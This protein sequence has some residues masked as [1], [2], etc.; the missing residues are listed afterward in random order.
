MSQLI[1]PAR[2]NKQPQ[3]AP[4][5]DWANPLTR[6]LGFLLNGGTKHN[7]LNGAPP[8]VSQLGKS[9]TP[10]GSVTQ[11][12]PTTNL[13]DQYDCEITGSEVS[14]FMLATPGG[15]QT[16]DQVLSV[17]VVGNTT[18]GYGIAFKTDPSSP[19]HMRACAW[20]AANGFTA[21]VD[22]TA[23][24]VGGKPVFFV[25]T[26]GGGFLT[27]Y[28]NGVQVASTA[29]S[30][31]FV[32]AANTIV[33]G[34]GQ[35]GYW[36]AD[37]DKLHIAGFY[38]RLLSPAEIKSLSAN[39]WQI[40]RKQRRLFF[41][42]SPAATTSTTS[43]ILPGS[44]VIQP[45]SARLNQASPQATGLIAAWPFIEGF[46]NVAGLPN[47]QIVYNGPT[48]QPTAGR[49]AALFNGTNQYLNAA[50]APVYPATVSGNW[51]V[52]FWARPLT[53]L[54]VRQSFFGT[55]NP[56]EYGTDFKINGNGNGTVA[57]DLGNGTTFLANPQWV[58][59]AQVGVWGHYC[60]VATPTGVQLYF[61]GEPLGLNTYSG[62]PLLWD[63]NH[64]IYIGQMGQSAEWFGGNISD[65]RVYTRAVS[66][67]EARAIYANPWQIFRR[68]RRLFFGSGGASSFP[69]GLV[70]ILG[71]SVQSANSLYQ[72]LALLSHANGYSSESASLHQQVSLLSTALGN[73]T[74]E[75]SLS[76]LTEMVAAMDGNSLLRGSAISQLAA[77]SSTMRGVGV[78]TSALYQLLSLASKETGNSVTVAS[79]LQD[80]FLAS[81][82]V[83]SSNAQG[84]LA[85]T[86]ALVSKLAGSSTLEASTLVFGF[87][88]YSALRGSSTFTVNSL[89]QALS[90][91]SEQEGSSSVAATLQQF[92]FLHSNATGEALLS[93]SAK[94]VL[95]MLSSAEGTSLLLTSLHQNAPL[96][97]GVVASALLASAIT[98]HAYIQSSLTGKS[99][100]SASLVNLLLVAARAEGISVEQAT[101]LDQLAKMV[102]GLDGASALSAQ[103][104]FGVILEILSAINGGSKLL[105]TKLDLSLLMSGKT[106]GYTTVSGALAQALKM[107]SE[108]ENPSTLQAALQSLLL[109][110]AQSTGYSEVEVTVELL[111]TL[112]HNFPTYYVVSL[113]NNEVWLVTADPYED[114]VVSAPSNAPNVVTFLR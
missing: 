92:F 47:A 68:Q 74:L 1:L 88:L 6:G 90:L 61:N 18:T 84:A 44:D 42:S 87:F 40:F 5:I 104:G 79:L 60:L 36:S 25:M 99:I 17:G 55:R 7:A 114:R 106:V 53:S 20:T 94:F 95:G 45:P 83:G 21:A 50:V 4:E 112:L 81:S 19:P 59:S 85:Q 98:Q 56:S 39:P 43:L 51:S 28:R 100:E 48:I 101:R 105:A 29:D 96:N 113:P 58:T 10:L 37:S 52:A 108:S 33:I 11:L 46:E 75:G 27:L 23:W 86:L 57:C 82:A 49:R 41:V 9:Y 67:G 22:P 111:T 109:L 91:L 54:S 38:N 8:T 3:S 107:A 76:Q 2:F 13:Y 31:A 35:N 78:E 15:T 12:A 80:A 64:E 62:T 66:A 26:F 103:M 70:K 16:F 69:L 89:H 34:A 97:S 14:L 32:V 72:L 102:S 77:L 63:A 65:F 110:E 24:N 30:N 93:A 71:T 73:G